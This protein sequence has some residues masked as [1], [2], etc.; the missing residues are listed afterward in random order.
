MKLL[1]TLIHFLFYS[2]IF[3]Q[4]QL[5]KISDF[6]IS[7][8]NIVSQF[9]QSSPKLFLNGRNRFLTTWQDSRDG[10][11][12][13]YA[14]FFDSLAHPV[15][16]NFKI[17]GDKK[18]VFNTDSSYMVISINYTSGGIDGYNIN[19][20]GN[21]Y[22]QNNNL[23]K[24]TK[25]GSIYILYESTDWIEK[26]Y[27]I[28][29]SK[30]GYLFC[31]NNH[32]YIEIKKVDRSGTLK[33]VWLPTYTD[34][35]GA[36]INR[37][38][39]YNYMI[40]Y[41]NGSEGVVDNDTLSQGLYASFFS[42]DD[43]LLAMDVLLDKFLGDQ[44]NTRFDK[45][46]LPQVKINIV[47]D[48]LFQVFWIYKDS[49]ALKY[50][51]FTDSGKQV[52]TTKTFALP[53]STLSNNEQRMLQNFT[54]SN[55]SGN[56][57]AVFISMTEG[58]GEYARFQNSI[59]YYSSSGE[60]VDVNYY[61]SKF[62]SLGEQIFKAK[63]NEFYLPSMEN[64]DIYLS[65]LSSSSINDILKINSEET[66]SND[67][68][69]FITVYDNT[70]NFV[71]WENETEIL[72]QKVDLSGNLLG[73]PVKLKGK[74]C[75]FSEDGKCFN[76][77]KKEFLPDSAQIGFSIYD[78][79]WKLIKDSSLAFSAKAYNLNSEIDKI[80]DS[81]FVQVVSNQNFTKVRT[82][83]NDFEV[84][85]EAS[86]TGDSKLMIKIFKNDN[87]SF[88][89]YNYNMKQLYSINLEPLSQA[90]SKIYA[91]F[92]IGNSRFLNT[93]NNRY[94]AYPYPYI[95]D[96]LIGKIYSV[97][98]DVIKDDINLGLAV[99]EYAIDRL[100]SNKFINLYRTDKS[101]YTRA[102]DN[103]GNMVADK[104][105]V[106]SNIVTFKKNPAFVL[107]NNKLC[108]VWAE[109]RTPGLGY[110]IYGSIIDLSYIV[111]VDDKKQNVIPEQ[112]SLSQNYPNPFNPTT[113]IKYTIPS[114]VDANRLNV[115]LKVYDVLGKKVATLVNKE[116][117]PG[118]YEVSFDGSKLSS[119]IYFYVLSYG[120]SILSRKMC[121][122]K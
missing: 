92:Y 63:E 4:S 114:N 83:T 72:G 61:D 41:F 67:V 89:M 37:N 55:F 113:K 93:Y 65:E 81:L 53:H 10:E 24:S 76:I 73:N 11:I 33:E 3:P 77:W 94:S 119:G 85:K 20:I 42:K 64:N 98:G 21:L 106:N 8:D 122:I 117:S 15:G 43:S 109:A 12:S 66:G 118:E 108:F 40:T 69:P 70:A 56:V 18:I 115:E 107:N 59:L 60:L 29:D 102:F 101:I 34:P 57:C 31:L 86:L 54:F 49:L 32:S 95:L 50:A 112:F 26:A 62:P 103:D 35:N 39:N 28:I 100:P 96:A 90:Y 17:A 46:N 104:F 13:T 14:Q 97:N 88:W 75:T 38:S 22:D 2:I 120:E 30:E 74:D 27:S 71:T 44:E 110:D 121:L 5:S 19:F 47:Q 51:V 52:G 79:D 58:T 48:T 25:V 45:N 7:T 68:N 111:S 78:K 16:V 105:I 6:K 99:D 87:N 23:I 91:D 84:I 1:F 82:L 9:I 36:W 80:N 116:Q